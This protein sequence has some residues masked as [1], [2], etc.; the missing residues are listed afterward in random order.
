[1]VHIKQTIDDNCVAAKTAMEIGFNGAETHGS[2]G[3]LTEQSLGSN[4]NEREGGSP[5]K[6]RA[7][8]LGTVKVIV[9]SF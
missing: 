5:E 9:K 4:T 2:D 3:P 8:Y 1:M 6:R 7:P